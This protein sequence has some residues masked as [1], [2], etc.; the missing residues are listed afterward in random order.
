MLRCRS[1]MKARVKAGC[2]HATCS[3]TRKTQSHS[4]RKVA[5]APAGS[6]GSVG[7][8]PAGLSTGSGA[9][10]SANASDTAILEPA[11]ESVQL[12]RDLGSSPSMSRP[13]GEFA[14]RRRIF[15][16]AEM[17]RL[18]YHFPD[19]VRTLTQSGKSKRKAKAKHKK[20]NAKWQDEVQDR[21]N[22]LV[23]R[24]KSKA[25]VS[26]EEED[27]PNEFDIESEDL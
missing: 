6:S 10:P 23:A 4:R 25:K 19:L 11:A 27:K 2:S 3:A 18:Q 22:N 15:D 9:R 24:P 17:E 21:F 12:L 5:S 7:A 1:V 26:A 20:E 16:D 8:P 13:P 14:H